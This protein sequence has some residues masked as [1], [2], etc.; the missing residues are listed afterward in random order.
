MNRGLTSYRQNLYVKEFYLFAIDRDPN[1]KACFSV[2]LVVTPL[3]SNQ[4]FN[5]ASFTPVKFLILYNLY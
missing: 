2:R 3:P 1:T 5:L 4:F